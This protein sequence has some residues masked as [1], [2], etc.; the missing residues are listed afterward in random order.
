[1]SWPTLQDY[2]EAIQNPGLAFSDPDLRRG[3]PELNQLGLGRNRSYSVA[4]S[5]T[6]FFLAAL[7]RGAATMK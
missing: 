1:M 3:L 6:N 4:V 5:H 7:S 2:N